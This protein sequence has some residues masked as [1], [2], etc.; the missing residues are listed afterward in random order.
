MSYKLALVGAGL[1]LSLSMDVAN[2]DAVTVTI[3]LQ[4][5]GVNG[6]AITTAATGND[7][8]AS[9]TGLAYGTFS[10]ISVTGVGYLHV[11]VGPGYSSL[12]SNLI[13]TSS[14]TPGVLT[15]LSNDALR[16]GFDSALFTIS[17]N[18]IV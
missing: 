3:S 11:P 9:V 6:G 2:A 15:M 4:E 17:L 8:T 18:S 16:T 1:A 14:S 7:G 10:S 5:A 13:A 12:F